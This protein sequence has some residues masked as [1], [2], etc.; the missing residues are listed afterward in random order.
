MA[1]DPQLIGQLI[2][3][4][5]FQ[6]DFGNAYEDG[7]II[8][9]PWQTGLNMGA[10]IG[11]VFGAFFAGIF[12]ERIGL[13]K[14]FAAC[15]LLIIGCVF[16]QF[17]ARSLAVLLVGEILAGLVLG[18][19]VV[20]APAYASEVAPLALRGPITASINLCFATGQLIANGTVDGTQK[21]STHWAYSIPFSIQWLWP[22]IIIVGYPFAPER[23][24]TF[25]PVIQKPLAKSFQSLVASATWTSRGSR[26]RSSSPVVF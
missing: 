7:Y 9:A 16:I 21:L 6:K 23:C 22:L 24:G 15:N 12:M 19:F 10:P 8:A 25:S 4:P 13:K 5:K 20:I 1:F 11:Q 3:T 18:C 17:F 26:K 2:A 14:S